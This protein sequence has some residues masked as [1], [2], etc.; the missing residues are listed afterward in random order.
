M[1]ILC[2]Y[3]N[4]KYR[5]AQRLNSLTGKYI[6]H[7]DK[8]YEFSPNDI[9]ATFR[10]AHKDIFAY[11]RGDGLWIWKPYFLC[12]LLEECKDGDTIFYCDSGAFFI[13]NVDP[14]YEL[15]DKE[16][17]IF[18]TDIPLI[19][20]CFTKQIC[21]DVIG[22]IEYKDM[23]QIQGGFILIKVCEYTK[24][25][26]KKWLEYCCNIDLISPSGV[27]PQNW[28]KIDI[29]YDKNFVSSREDQSI[30]SL[31][32]HINGIKAHR[33]ISQKGFDPKS[34]YNKYYAYREPKHDDTYKSIVYLHRCPNIPTLIARRVYYNLHLNKLKQKIKLL[35]SKKTRHD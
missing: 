5:Q 22:G 4:E 34:Y 23:N 14:L 24:E 7:F 16:K 19:E 35:F 8:V 25:F 10:E 29:F 15:L 33:D 2:N 11:N 21:F 26:V 18:V 30:L 6:A 17:P 13:R 27:Q 20:S 31:L 12:R 3:A 28:G 32:C 9:D 1:R